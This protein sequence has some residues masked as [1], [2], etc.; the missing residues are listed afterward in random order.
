MKSINFIDPVP[1]QKQR[2]LQLWFYGSAC[3]IIALV[4]SM[5]VVHYARLRICSSTIQELTELQGNNVQFE[6]FNHRKKMLLK[7]QQDIQQRLQT[8]GNMR[9]KNGA[10]HRLL[11]MLARTIPTTVRITNIEGELGARITMVCEAADAKA[12]VTFLELLNASPYVDDMH[13]TSIGEQ[14]KIITFTLQGTWKDAAESVQQH[15]F[16]AELE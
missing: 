13:L 12:A 5:V 7:E 10:A 14:K 2:E 6:Q 3:F 1:P 9:Q 16:P 4:I 8:L 15:E 11:T